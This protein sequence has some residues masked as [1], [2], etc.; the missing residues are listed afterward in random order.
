MVESY[1][2]LIVWQKAI[3]LTLE[4]YKL[5]DCYPTDEKFGLTGQMRRAA[6]SI[7]SNIAEGKY[8]N[9]RKDFARFLYQAFSSGGELETQIHISKRLDIVKDLNHSRVDKLLSEVMN[10]LNSLIQSLNSR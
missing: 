1:R 10:M 7:A 8:R 9:S 6:V 3:D 2:E 4:I 5:T